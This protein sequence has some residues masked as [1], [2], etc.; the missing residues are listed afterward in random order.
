MRKL[1]KPVSVLCAVLIVLPGCDFLS[2]HKEAV[3]G[4]AIG[5][6][7]GGALGYAAGGRHHRGRTVALGAV[8]GA[9]AGAAIGEYMSQRDRTAQQ[10]QQ[11]TNYQP[12]QGIVL[13]MD[14]ASATPPMVAGSGQVVLS[15]TYTL[16]APQTAQTFPVTESRKVTLN[17]MAVADIPTTVDRQPGTFTSQVPIVL[18]AGATKGNYEV[19][20]TVSAAGQF[21]QKTTS[22]TVQ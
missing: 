8:L 2:Q 12:A 19:L 6:V 4:A 15:A 22:F 14:G 17:G 1:S 18:P 3:T 20:V 13:Q 11:A 10:A 7:A 16:L 9:L 5:A 21:A